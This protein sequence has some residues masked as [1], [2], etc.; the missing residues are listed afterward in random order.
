M[1]VLSIESEIF[2]FQLAATSTTAEASSSSSASATSAAA[3]A[4]PL[5][6]NIRVAVR[7]RPENAAEEANGAHRNVVEIVDERMLVFDPKQVNKIS[8]SLPRTT[9]SY[10]VALLKPKSSYQMLPNVPLHVSR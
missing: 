8:S 6:A 7:V 1:C 10:V 4:L 9:S 3:A 5:P 2:S